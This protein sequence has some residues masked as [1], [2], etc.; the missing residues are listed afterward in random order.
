MDN[1]ICEDLKLATEYVA[2]RL[3]TRLHNVETLTASL[4]NVLNCTGYKLS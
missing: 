4:S 1:I 3:G 2:V